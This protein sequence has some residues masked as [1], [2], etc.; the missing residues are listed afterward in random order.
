MAKHCT[1]F[2]DPYP[3]VVPAPV[4]ARESALETENSALR[5]ERANLHEKVKDLHHRLKAST[6]AVDTVTGERDA[7][8]AILRLLITQSTVVV[9]AIE[10]HD[11]PVPGP[12][13]F[14]RACDPY[15][16]RAT[17]AK[18]ILLHET[19]CPALLADRY[20]YELRS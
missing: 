9:D 16:L 4:S 20:F 6:L 17:T 7:L 18:G 10:G 13:K 11:L 14:C 1:A 2:H 8:R 5:A 12:Y 19:D 15:G 3:I